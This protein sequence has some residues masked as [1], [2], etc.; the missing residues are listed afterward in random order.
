[1]ERVMATEF[2]FLI[3]SIARSRA[4]SARPIYLS[5]RGLEPAK[6]GQHEVIRAGKAGPSNP[7]HM[8]IRD[9]GSFENGIVA[10]SR[11]HSERVPG[12]DD[13]IT[14]GVTRHNRVHYFRVIG[15]ARIR[16]IDV[17]PVP[18]GRQRAEMPV[19][20]KSVTAI[21]PLG[22]RGRVDDFEVIA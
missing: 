13:A 17:E 10:L 2:F 15:V 19:P 6:E 4:R 18:N 21:D 8:L 14:C 16:T 5:D 22:T 20:V 11:S 3:L 12:L 1:M 9:E 7:E